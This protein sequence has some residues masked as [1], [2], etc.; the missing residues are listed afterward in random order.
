VVFPSNA[1]C[2]QSI[3]RT[4]NLHLQKTIEKLSLEKLDIVVELKN[5]T[6]H[7][8]YHRLW[9]PILYKPDEFLSVYPW[10]EDYSWWR[11]G[12]K[13][14]AEALGYTACSACT[15]RTQFYQD[16][17]EICTERWFQSH[18]EYMSIDEM[19]KRDNKRIE[20][21]TLNPHHMKGVK[22]EE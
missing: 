12:T 13:E 14:E 15:F 2:S 4:R 6:H 3:Q 18:K 9:C 19:F 1:T 10:R 5:P 21:Q 8:F 20:S 17:E 22:I 7:E 16:L 11:R